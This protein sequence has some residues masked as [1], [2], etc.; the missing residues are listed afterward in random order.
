[1]IAEFFSAGN[2]GKGESNPKS[3]TKIEAHE[4][5]LL[6]VPCVELT[7]SYNYYYYYLAVMR[8][9]LRCIK[10]KNKNSS[11]LGCF[12]VCVW[13]RLSLSCN[14]HSSKDNEKGRGGRASYEILL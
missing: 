6:F 7:F 4:T 13:I 14:E 1:M 12:N 9:F 5:I 11:I 8:D 3:Y 10:N 2:I